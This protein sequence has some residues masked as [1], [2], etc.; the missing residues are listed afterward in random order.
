MNKIKI[1]LTILFLFSCTRSHKKIDM[2]KSSEIWE[3]VSVQYFT[4]GGSTSHA[5]LN[6]DGQIIHIWVQEP[7]STKA[8]TLTIFLK[9]S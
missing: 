5:Y 1:I 7:M 8:Q 4:D 6:D 2:V 3:L 9:D